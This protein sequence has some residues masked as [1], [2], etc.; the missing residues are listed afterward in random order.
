MLYELVAVVSL[1]ALVCVI[2]SVSAFAKRHRSVLAMWLRSKSTPA[3][4]QHFTLPD[5]LS[6]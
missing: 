1:S 4:P 3:V 2:S 6:S 5:H